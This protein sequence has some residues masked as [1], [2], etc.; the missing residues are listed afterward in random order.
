LFP[1]FRI[2]ATGLFPLIFRGGFRKTVTLA[3]IAITGVLSARKPA[4]TELVSLVDRPR[5]L[6]MVWMTGTQETHGDCYRRDND[7]L[8]HAEK[9]RGWFSG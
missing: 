8:S 1:F 9:H 3:R 5:G 6:S 2:V 7:D 4:N